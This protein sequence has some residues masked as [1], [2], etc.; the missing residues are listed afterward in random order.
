MDLLPVINDNREV[1]LN[2]KITVE[3]I[4]GP[5]PTSGAQSP[6]SSKSLNSTFFVA[7]N[8]TLVIG[9]IIRETQ[10]KTENQFPGL[11]SLSRIPVISYFVKSK[12]NQKE[13]SELLL[14]ITPHI[15]ENPIESEKVGD[16]I[17]REY[18]EIIKRNL[19]LNTAT[20][21]ELS[22]YYLNA[23][24]NLTVEQ[25]LEKLQLSGIQQYNIRKA[26]PLW[27]TQ[28]ESLK[29]AESIAQSIIDYR[30]SFG[31]ITN[32]E[33][34]QFISIPFN[35]I[36]VPIQDELYNAIVKTTTLDININLSDVD[37]FTQIK[38]IDF[39][40]AKKIIKHR[41]EKGYFSSKK[42]FSELIINL[43][44]PE[45]YYEKF[46]EPVIIL[47]QYPIKRPVK[48]DNTTAVP[49][50]GSEKPE[51]K[52]LD[53]DKSVLNENFQRLPEKESSIPEPP[54]GDQPPV[55]KKGTY[56]LD[57]KVNLNTVS[58]LELQQIFKLNKLQALSIIK[59]RERY[60]VFNSVE[61]IKNIP[62]FTD[63][64]YYRLKDAIVV[65]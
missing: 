23:I 48:K 64:L 38:S 61:D 50:A 58:P 28:K 25:V 14:F 54:A 21:V 11:D 27:L 47:T 62:G 18:R 13:N 17:K 63:E 33:Q 10:T 7:D 65:Y 16:E 45:K 57:S 5:P 24:Y 37:A 32:F 49:A 52:E 15:I 42:E 9:G 40:T 19:S 20:R 56:T 34:L 46:L 8:Q 12:D 39:T 35:K 6:V 26:L 53:F 59:Y 60:G 31:P 43:G 29:F 44:V 51:K 41:E 4:S 2:V 55:K 1:L 36:K 30:N 3:E 22:R